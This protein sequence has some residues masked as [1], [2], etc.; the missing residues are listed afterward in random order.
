MCLVHT[1]VNKHMH[2][3]K[4]TH[5]H[6]HAHA[7]TH[8]RTHTHTHTEGEKD[9]RENCSK[10]RSTAAADENGI[11]SLGRAFALSV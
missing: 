9:E 11:S 4:R 8:A 1:P 6:A 3:H 2:A 5:T 10:I 7:R